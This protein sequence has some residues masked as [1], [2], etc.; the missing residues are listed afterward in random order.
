M[1]DWE[2]RSAQLSLYNNR[3]IVANNATPRMREQPMIQ[4]YKPRDS[5]DDL[6][7]VAIAFAAIVLIYGVMRGWFS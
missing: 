6:V 3:K 2:K 5:G 1:L 4:R 7:L